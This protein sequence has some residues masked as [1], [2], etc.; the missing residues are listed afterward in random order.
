MA[1]A[2]RTLGLDAGRL[3]L[4]DRFL[5]EKYLAPGRLPCAMTLVARGGEIAHWGVQGFADLERGEKITEDTVF[6]IYSMTKPV[7]SVALMMLVEEGRIA[8]DDPVHRHI[9][10]WKNLAVFEAGFIGTFRTKRPARPMLV[11]DLLR[12]TAGLTYGFQNRTNV[13]AAYRKRGIGDL[14]HKGSLATMIEGLA[15]LPLEFSPGAAWNYSVATDVCGY[16]VQ[17]VSGIPFPQFLSERIFAPLGMCDTGFE[18]APGAR[19]RFASCYM[20]T[21]GG[22]MVRS[23]DAR[24]SVYLAPPEFVSGGG[25]LVSTAADYLKFCRMLI[26]GGVLDGQ[27][28]L[29]RKTVELMT[30]NHLPGGR[31]LTD[32]SLSLFSEA[33][34]D[35]IGFGLG[36]AVTVDPVRTLLP[37]SAGEYSWGGAASTYFW[38]DPKE[39]L[40]V[41]FMTQLL[42]S[43][44][45]PL[46]REL[47]TMAYAALT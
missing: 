26:Q 28:L 42:P 18:V 30:Q 17:A 9:P 34:Y 1:A 24:S 7:T 21:P 12:H 37:G 16:L 15:D 8:L 19:E 25:G 22:G 40:I 27:R 43:T 6:R 20:A 39:D 14:P 41:I 36:F 13:D 11:V 33:A 3:A 10:A 35:G 31:F 45:Y 47:R 29:G 5:A 4:M 44:L 38:I 46:R 32:M 2:P 23:D